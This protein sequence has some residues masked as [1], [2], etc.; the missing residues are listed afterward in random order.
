MKDFDPLT[1]LTRGPAV[2]DAYPPIRE[3]TDQARDKFKEYREFCCALVL[4]NLG[5][6]YVVLENPDVM[7][8]AMYG[9]SGFRFPV[10][11]QTG[12]GN[13]DGMQR[14]FLGRG[15]MI[16]P[17]WSK[18]QNTIISAVI[19]LTII[20]PD[21]Q[22][23]V[24]MIRANPHKEIDDCEAELRTALPT[25]DATV[26]LPRVLV[27]HNAVAR[28]RFPANLFCGAHDSHFGILGVDHDVT[29]RGAKLPSSLE[30]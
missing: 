3:K 17:N 5:N 2:F 6:P 24:E 12:I 25:Y 14:T 1:H 30:R 8:G 9:D 4:R 21:Y 20:R 26:T 15:K 13:A 22:R 7:L 27:W 11:K 19:T 23:L 10:N 16:R 18:P 28:V 29:F